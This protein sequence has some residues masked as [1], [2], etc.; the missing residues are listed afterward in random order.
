MTPDCVHHWLLGPPTKGQC[1]ARCKLCGE[2]RVF[3]G[4]ESDYGYGFFAPKQ[5][6]F[7]SA[8]EKIILNS[9]GSL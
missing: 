9:G 3:T 7:E 8:I 6:A 1:E 5:S 4:G 2:E